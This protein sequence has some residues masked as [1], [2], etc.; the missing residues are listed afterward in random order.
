[1]SNWPGRVDSGN[2]IEVLTHP[3]CRR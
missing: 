3:D 2:R 1:M